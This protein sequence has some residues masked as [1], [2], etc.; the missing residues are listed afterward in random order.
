MTNE[1]YFPFNIHLIEK[2]DGNYKF[3]VNGGDINSFI[4]N[5]YRGEFSSP[6]DFLPPPQDSNLANQNPYY[7][8]NSSGKPLFDYSENLDEDEKEIEKITTFTIQATCDIYLTIPKIPA[9]FYNDV[10]KSKWF[11][12]SAPY[13]FLNQFSIVTSLDEGFDE[14][15]L[16]NTLFKGDKGE[17]SLL[18]SGFVYLNDED[19]P[20]K[21]YIKIANIKIENN[22]TFINYFFRSNVISPLRYI[23]LGSLKM[24]NIEILFTS[25]SESKSETFIDS[26]QTITIKGEPDDPEIEGDQSTKDQEV[27][28][29]RNA[30]KIFIPIVNLA[31]VRS[32]FDS[33]YLFNK[34]IKEIKT[35]C[36][37]LLKDKINFIND[38][39]FYGQLTS[40][41]TPESSVFLESLGLKF[42]KK[43]IKIFQIIIIYK[44]SPNGKL[45]VENLYED[46]NGY[47]EL[48]KKIRDANDKAFK[49]AGSVNTEQPI[50][51]KKPMN[52]SEAYSIIGI[53]EVYTE[54]EKDKPNK[55]IDLKPENIV[56]LIGFEE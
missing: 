2:D 54:T 16:K 31:E 36:L 52:K 25:I 13:S 7:P 26:T 3:G 32:T 50:E 42:R 6:Y 1:I 48:V 5:T 14:K 43:S 49:S 18:S 33:P 41:R 53:K 51:L 10:D 17:P 23:R 34:T 19:F 35:L 12:G 15:Y 40:Q 44:E 45:I 39:Y 27:P 56:D 24:R 47:N 29:P 30:A 11:Y 21:I 37:P 4:F 20:G 55:Y 22:E 9:G 8:R 28:I 46:V 38:T